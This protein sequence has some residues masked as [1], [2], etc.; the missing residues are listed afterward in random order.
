MNTLKKL[1]CLLLASTFI[2]GSMASCANND[3]DKDT[4]KKTQSAVKDPNNERPTFEEED[5]DEDEF[6]FLHY[7]ET[8]KDFHDQ[9]IW[10][11][12]FTGGTIGDAVI[13]RNQL[14]EDEYNV[15]ITAEECGPMSEATTRM[16]A[17]QCDFEVIYEWGI[18]SKGA[19]LDGQL[20]DFHELNYINLDASY[21]VPSAVEGLT[22]ADRMFVATNMVSMNAISWAGIYYFNKM[23]MDKLGLDYPYDYVTSNTWTYDVVLE[24]CLAAEEDVNGDGEMSAEDQIGG[25]SG[26][27]ILYG[28]CSAPLVE[29]NG[30]G[31]YKLIPYTEGMVAQYSKYETKTGSVETINWEKY[32]EGADI[33][34]FPSQFVA[35]RF[36]SFGEDH[37]LFMGGSIDM[38][39]EFVNMQSDYGIVPEPTAKAGDEYSC[40]VDYCAPMF[41]IPIQVE[42]PDM[43]AIVFEYLAY[44]SE[45]LLLPAYYE[46]TIKTKRME[47]QRD[48]TMLDIVRDSIGYNW[49]GL[50]M[51]D[52]EL[53]QLRGRMLSSG[54]FA[55]VAKR[56]ET[57]CQ[58]E[59]DEL[60]DTI[61]SIE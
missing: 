33:S 36:L 42:D 30:D 45:R 46:T 10:S 50:Y 41:S 19:A 56:Y 60:V 11:E 48:Y 6:K 47:D 22:V 18:R 39:K 4:P 24:M 25:V 28:V 40:G 61:T 54:N 23:L 21:W 7:G 35:A 20:Y 59:I 8:A 1:L 37:Q 26:E 5:F 38:T 43:A 58:A 15:K 52:S 34:G 57:K 3:D 17:G 51:W 16:Q 29:D 12:D 44:E 55:S 31:T 14:V 2:V 53:S 9:Y 49:V 32:L 13:E 27:T